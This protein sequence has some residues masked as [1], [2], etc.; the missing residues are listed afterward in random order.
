MH[1]IVVCEMLSSADIENPNSK[2]TIEASGN[3]IQMNAQLLRAKNI[4]SIRSAIS[5]FKQI[6]SK[7]R[8]NER[9]VG[10]SLQPLIDEYFFE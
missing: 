8:M 3:A 4:D 7:C 2:E 9:L 5:F 10:V 6:A 1:A